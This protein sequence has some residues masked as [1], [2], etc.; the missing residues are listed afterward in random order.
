MLKW[1]L[2]T[3]FSIPLMATPLSVQQL[4]VLNHSHSLG[5]APLAD[6]DSCQ[7]QDHHPVELLKTSMD[8]QKAEINGCR[9]H[10]CTGNIGDYPQKVRILLPLDAS[11]AYK[12]FQYHFHGHRFGNN[13]DL[14]LDKLVT[15]MDL[16]KK[17][18]GNNAQTM[19]V[20]FSYGQCADFDAYFRSQDDFNKFHR[21]ILD[22]M[23]ATQSPHLTL[24]A[25]SGGGR[26]L[27]KI[28]RA[29]E[30]HISKVEIY[31]GIYSWW[32]PEAIETWYKNTP[33][34]QLK[35]IALAPAGT[36]FSNYKNK[37]GASPF[38]YSKQI[39]EGLTTTNS[40]NLVEKENSKL[41]SVSAEHDGKN[42]EFGFEQSTTCDHYTVLKHWF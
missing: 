34:A 38:N 13:Y 28:I 2:L 41:Y 15:N 8:C 35:M 39:F 21:N 16:Y 17:S 7:Q 36:N 11:D 31:D 20:P 29:G 6:C 14:N 37:S 19:I 32:Q 22:K 3:L 25:H 40:Q 4:D 24:S 9:F 23:G 18:C 1:L 26:A 42:A 27:G 12:S 10:Q 33:E 30:T 5:Q